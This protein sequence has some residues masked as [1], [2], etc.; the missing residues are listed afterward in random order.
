VLEP[1]MGGGM[2][3]LEP[4]RVIQYRGMAR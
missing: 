1:M 2:V 3:T 4:V